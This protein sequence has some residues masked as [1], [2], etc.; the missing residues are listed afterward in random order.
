MPELTH[1]N[2]RF[3]N[4]II[5]KFASEIFF[6]VFTQICDDPSRVRCAIFIMF[7]TSCKS[8]K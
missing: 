3:Y 8:E 4:N 2:D 5:H 1:T 6:L 7:F